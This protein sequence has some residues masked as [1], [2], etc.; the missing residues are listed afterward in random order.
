[1]FDWIK[2]FFT[3]PEFFM[4]C[5]KRVPWARVWV[6]L[7]GALM[8]AGIIPVDSIADGAGYWAGLFSVPVAFAV[9]SKGKPVP[10]PPIPSI[11]D[12]LRNASPE[13][14]SAARAHLKLSPNA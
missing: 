14:I 3:D 1:M 4:E 5:I 10:P 8:K 6:V 7:V 11:V 9:P 2:R 13:E 12:Q